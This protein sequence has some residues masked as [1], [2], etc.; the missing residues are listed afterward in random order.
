MTKQT[1]NYSRREFTKLSAMGIASIP[2]L[3]CQNGLITKE[4]TSPERLNVHLF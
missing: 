4:T 2:L 3:A 1:V